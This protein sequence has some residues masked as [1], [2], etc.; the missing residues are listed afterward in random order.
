VATV[1]QQGVLALV[2]ARGSV[3]VHNGVASFLIRFDPR[4]SAAIDY[5]LAIGSL[6]QAALKSVLS[7]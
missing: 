5:P 1:R 7:V 2:T 6:T 3:I 4:S